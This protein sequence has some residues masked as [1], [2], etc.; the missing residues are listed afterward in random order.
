LFDGGGLAAVNERSPWQTCVSS[1]N[2]RRSDFGLAMGLTPGQASL[3]S[4]LGQVVH[5]NMP[6]SPSSIFSG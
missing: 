4:K 1:W 3:L 2:L 5:T 6:L